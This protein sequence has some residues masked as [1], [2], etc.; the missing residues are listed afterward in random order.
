M[1]HSRINI[2]S[3]PEQQLDNTD[4]LVGDIIEIKLSENNVEKINK[5]NKKILERK[6]K[7]SKIWIKKKEI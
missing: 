4:I 1:D 6:N 7:K 3:K 5:N 2:Y